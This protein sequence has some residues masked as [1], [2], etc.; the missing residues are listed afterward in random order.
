MF[1]YLLF[2][3]TLLTKT[4]VC[5]PSLYL[6]EIEDDKNEDPIDNMMSILQEAEIANKTLT[7]EEVEQLAQDYSDYCNCHCTV[8]IGIVYQKHQRGGGEENG[9]GGGGGIC[10]CHC[11]PCS[12][13]H[14]HNGGGGGGGCSV[15]G[16][17]P[18]ITGEELNIS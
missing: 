17:V 4:V 6:V 2:T 9:A 14:A 7:E 1:L 18:P 8:N 10:N 15:V 3:L 11:N 5:H 16:P 12:G 13:G